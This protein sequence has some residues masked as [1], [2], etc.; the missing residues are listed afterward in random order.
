M[1][2]IGRLTQWLGGQREQAV[3]TQEARFVVV[4]T[5]LTGLDPRKDDIVSIG[6]VRMLGG[7]LDIGGA[8]YEL[9]RPSAVLDA[10]SIVIHRITPSQIE[11]MPLIDDILASFLAYAG[12]AVLLGHCVSVDLG[13]LNREA[14]RLNGA[15]LANPT[16]DTLS[17][18]GW[19]RHRNMDH[20]AFQLP[21]P[22]ISLFTL[23]KAFDIPVENAHTALGD[24]Y[25][26]AQLFQ[27]FLPLLAEAGVTELPEL[28]RIGDPLRQAENLLAPGG[29]VHF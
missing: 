4:D 10:R 27:R 24:A 22:Q 9:V 15:P 20:P 26:T 7:R 1:G 23:A 21:I 2:L 19:L 18:Y 16:V 3:L 6:A 25:V 14:R 11:A 5:E 29:Q 13:F 12:E 8:F 17:M 28:L